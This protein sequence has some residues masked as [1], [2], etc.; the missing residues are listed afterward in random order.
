MKEKSEKY[1]NYTGGKQQGLPLTVY[2]S[3]YLVL[4]GKGSRNDFFC[5][6]K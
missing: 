1:V 4:S 6:H 3:A 5:L 2:F